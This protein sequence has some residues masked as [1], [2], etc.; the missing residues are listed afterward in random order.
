MSFTYVTGQG[1]CA[2]CWKNR[3]VIMISQGKFNLCHKCLEEIVY[4]NMDLK[5][6]EK[7]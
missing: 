5:E 1:M 7:V 2:R 4:D 6:G 3:K